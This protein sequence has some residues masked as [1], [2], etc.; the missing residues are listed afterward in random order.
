M[1]ISLNPNGG[2]R[3][4]Q[5]IVSQRKILQIARSVPTSSNFER[6]DALLSSSSIILVS[7]ASTLSFKDAIWF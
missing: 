7:L 5:D 6:S 3:L 2:T 1:L 4:G